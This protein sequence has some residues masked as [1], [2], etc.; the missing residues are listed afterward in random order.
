[1]HFF[2]FYIIENFYKL[3]ILII[4]YEFYAITDEKDPYIQLVKTTVSWLILV[5]KKIRNV[6][7]PMLE[8]P[9]VTLLIL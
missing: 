7:A 6:I 2:L 1:M 9:F 3:T 4:F 8:L 5:K